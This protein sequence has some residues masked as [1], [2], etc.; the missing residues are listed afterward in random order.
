[1]KHRLLHFK[2]KKEKEEKESKLLHNMLQLTGGSVSCSNNDDNGGDEERNINNDRINC[3]GDDNG[4]GD[5][6]IVVVDSLEECNDYGKGGRVGGT[7]EQEEGLVMMMKDSV[8]GVQKAE[9]GQGQLWYGSVTRHGSERWLFGLGNQEQVVGQQ[10]MR[11]EEKKILPSRHPTTDII[12]VKNEQNSGYKEAPQGFMRRI[13]QKRGAA[14]IMYPNEIKSG[15]Q[16]GG[17]GV[18]QLG[19]GSGNVS[20]SRKVPIKFVFK[21]HDVKLTASFVFASSSLMP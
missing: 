12:Q 6:S 21:I 9:P 18:D 16:F 2:K 15:L 1:M 10:G 5:D 11:A 14:S 13:Q 8:C 4:D 19:S 17:T 20:S 3:N 7:K